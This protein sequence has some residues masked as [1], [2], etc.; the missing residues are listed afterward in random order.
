MLKNPKVFTFI[1]QGLAES[2]QAIP[3]RT[4]GVASF[5]FVKVHHV[6]HEVHRVGDRMILTADLLHDGLKVF[7]TGTIHDTYLSVQHLI[8]EE[9]AVVAA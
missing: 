6:V 2:G 7:V 4:G 9:I 8:V 5:K 3:K 1:P